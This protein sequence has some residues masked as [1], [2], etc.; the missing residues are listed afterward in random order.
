[1]KHLDWSETYADKHRFVQDKL[2]PLLEEIDPDIVSVNYVAVFQGSCLKEASFEQ[3][4]INY[5]NGKR[6]IN[7]TMDSK[8]A[9]VKDVLKQL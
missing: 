1:M 4:D 2:A 5:P 6:I 7:V 9:I 3:V 8:L